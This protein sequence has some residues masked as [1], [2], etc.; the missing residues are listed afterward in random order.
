[1]IMYV[2]NFEG[3]MIKTLLKDVKTL[4]EEKTGFT[5]IIQVNYVT[6]SNFVYIV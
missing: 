1:M 3:G 6:L 4:L 2:W 5:V